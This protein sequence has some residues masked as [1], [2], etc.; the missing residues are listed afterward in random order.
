MG[1]AFLGLFGL[2]GN[3]IGSAVV[4]LTFRNNVFFLILAV[5]AVT[6]VWKF[7]FQYVVSY[8]RSRRINSGVLQGAAIAGAAA[9]LVISTMM[10]AGSS[11]TP[12]LYNQF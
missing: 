8:L 5:L 11:Y 6:P 7:A 12:F 4:S 1:R 3:G 9:L 10:M 2:N